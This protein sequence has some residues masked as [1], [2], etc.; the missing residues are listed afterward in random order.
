MRDLFIVCVSFRYQVLH[1]HLVRAPSL[2]PK[3][4][5][6]TIIYYFHLQCKFKKSWISFS[7]FWQQ[8]TQQI[9]YNIQAILVS[10][11]CLATTSSKRVA[12]PTNFSCILNKLY[13][14]PI[15]IVHNLLNKVGFVIAKPRIVLVQH[16]MKGMGW[17]R[18]KMQGEQEKIN[19]YNWTLTIFVF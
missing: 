19:F 11:H 7:R 15:H 8:A 17:Y 9:T 10:L 1:P 5:R 16:W 3:T 6:A 2:T 12:T 14:F 4:L 13:P 18:R